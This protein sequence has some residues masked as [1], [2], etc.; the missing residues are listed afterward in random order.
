MAEDTL[1]ADKARADDAKFYWLKEGYTPG[2]FERQIDHSSFIHGTHP[3][4]NGIK[5][6]DCDTHFTEPPD[7]FERNVPASMKGKMPRRGAGLRHRR[8]QRHPA[9]QAQ[10]ARPP[11]V[12]D[13]RGG[14]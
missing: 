13:D 2:G 6:V 12:P 10:A 7:M 11:V 5:I 9:G 1:L 14:H 8:R 4:F 3:L